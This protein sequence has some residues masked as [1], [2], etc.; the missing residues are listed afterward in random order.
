MADPQP[1][2][3]EDLNQLTAELG[4]LSPKELLVELTSAGITQWQ[5]AI[6][7]VIAHLLAAQSEASNNKVVVGAVSEHYR[8]ATLTADNLNASGKSVKDNI[9]ASLNAAI[10]LQRIIEESFRQIQ[11]QTGG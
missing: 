2:S 8:S 7:D 10:A 4:Q 6:N 3:I 11:L 5:T 9:D 1:P